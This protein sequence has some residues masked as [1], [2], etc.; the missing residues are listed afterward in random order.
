MSA[1][2]Y[3]CNWCGK[4]ISGPS[5]TYNEIM[6]ISTTLH[7]GDKHIVIGC[8]TFGAFSDDVDMCNIC[9]KKIRDDIVKRLSDRNKE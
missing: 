2:G 6:D 3:M 7:N 5:D 8:L 1:K 4:D 9:R